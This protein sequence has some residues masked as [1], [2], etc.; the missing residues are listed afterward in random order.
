MVESEVKRQLEENNLPW[1][2]FQK[3]MFG[4]TVSVLDNGQIEYY[5]WDVNRYV[6]AMLKHGNTDSTIFD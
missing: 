1:E 2:D 4:Q 5:D 6:A 3:W